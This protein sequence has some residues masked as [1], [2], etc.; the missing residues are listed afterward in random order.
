MNDVDVLYRGPL[1]DVT[2]YTVKEL[3]WRPGT[4]TISMAPIPVAAPTE[5]PQ[6][7]EPVKEPE[8][9]ASEPPARCGLTH[10]ICP[11]G[12][13]VK[14]AECFAGCR[15]PDQFPG[16]RCLPLPVL[17]MMFGRERKIVP[18]RYS[19]TELLNPTRLAYLRRTTEYEES[20]DDAWFRTYGTAVHAML[21]G[22]ADNHLAE[23]RLHEEGDADSGGGQFDLYDGTTKTLFDL[24]VTGTYKGKKIL[25]AGSFAR[26]ESMSWAIQLNRYRQKLERA[27]FEVERMV[28][29]MFFRDWGFRERKAGFPKFAQATVKRISDHWLDRY[30]RMKADALTKAHETGYAPVCKA[31]DIWGG[32]RCKGYCPVS[33]ACREMSEEHGEYH[34]AFGWPSVRTEEEEA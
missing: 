33:A 24:K 19:T 1:R 7:S 23:V 22:E 14:T 31:R 32:R 18:G 28:L 30:Y 34:P 17:T 16:R 26:A 8:P 29:Q 5:L 21:E 13:V 3:G 12:V 11:D 25:K 20:P 4:F 6:G 2:C 27:G 9:A 10:I 15:V